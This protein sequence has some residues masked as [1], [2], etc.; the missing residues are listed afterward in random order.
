ML[1][2]CMD[3]YSLG[4]IAM[5]SCILPAQNRPSLGGSEFVLPRARWIFARFQLNAVTALSEAMLV[6]ALGLGSDAA[7]GDRGVSPTWGF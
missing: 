4:P 6:Q 5:G 2:S 3:V 7:R 1:L